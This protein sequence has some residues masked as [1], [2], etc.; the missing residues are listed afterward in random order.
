MPIYNQT[1]KKIVAMA[2]H[3]FLAQGIKR[4]TIED[5]A[6]SCGVT[7]ATVYRYFKDKKNLVY[8]SLI[9]LVNLLDEAL[10][11]I[12]NQNDYSAE[13]S[14]ERIKE[15]VN[16]LPRGKLNVRLDELKQLYPDIFIE[17]QKARLAS[18]QKLYKSVFNRLKRDKLVLPSET[19]LNLLLSILSETTLYVAESPLVMAH[20]VSVVDIYTAILDIMLYGIVGRGKKIKPD[21]KPVNE[22]V[23]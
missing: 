9:H 14:A 5:V 20:G 19:D 10:A 8:V 4:T 2:L 12:G 6:D 16:V 23:Y 22:L 7:R 18:I 21:R 15:A 17:Y 3:L 13:K 1:Q 11:D